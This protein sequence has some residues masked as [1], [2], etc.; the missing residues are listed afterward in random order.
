MEHPEEIKNI[1]K[2]FN[3]YDFDDILGQTEEQFIKFLNK[4]PGVNKISPKHLLIS[5]TIIDKLNI[6]NSLFDKKG[7]PINIFSNVPLY[8]KREL[9][10]D[11]FIHFLFESSDK[12]REFSL[13]THKIEILSYIQKLIGGGEEDEYSL[14]LLLEENHL[15]REK[16]FTLSSPLSPEN[17]SSYEDDVNRDYSFDAFSRESDDYLDID[18]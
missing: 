17:N 13:I 18:Y 7:K 10:I 2:I 12:K 9:N 3:Q 11:K 8:G 4:I 14:P 6:E 16:E 15:P 1:V 5:L